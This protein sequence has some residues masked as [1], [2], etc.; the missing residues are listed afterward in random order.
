VKHLA[1]VAVAVGAGA[2]IVWAA[3]TPIPPAEIKA[4]FGTGTPFTASSA[5]GSAKFSFVLKPDGTASRTTKGTTHDT[6]VT[7][8]WRVDDKGYCTKW[9]SKGTEQC[10]TVEKN[11][12]QYAVKDSAGKVV[13]HWTL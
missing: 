8:T 3:T 4:T 2:G 5:T 13:S 10:Y 6:T 7:G 11:G 9:G 1:V 12:K